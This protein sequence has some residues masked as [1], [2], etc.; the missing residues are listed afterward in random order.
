MRSL[1]TFLIFFCCYICLKAQAPA[2]VPGEILIQL[3]RRKEAS[4]WIQNHL[5]KRNSNYP[6]IR[7]LVPVA[8]LLHIWKIEFDTTCTSELQLLQQLRQDPAIAFAQFNHY[9][10]LRGIQPNDPL[11]PQQWQWYNRGQNGGDRGLD[12]GLYQAWD[13]TTGGL[14]ATGDSIVV[15]IIDSGLEAQH[16][17]LKPNTWFNRHEIPNNRKDDDGN[18]YIDDYRGWHTLQFNDNV[19]DNRLDGHGTG[20]AGLI[21]AKG[22]N[23][24]GMAGINW[25]IKLMPIVWGGENNGTEEVVIRGFTY[26]YTQRKLYNESK[27]KKGAYVV[28]VNA[29]WGISRLRSADFPI[30]CPLLDSLGQ[31]GV[32]TV[33]AAD[34]EMINTEELGDLPSDCPSNYL[35]V[36]TNI[37]NRGKL[38][39]AYGPHTVDL[40]APAQDILSTRLGE[41]YREFSGSSFAAPQV[42][43]AIALLYASPC[44][45]LANLAQNSPGEAALLA[46]RL[47]MDGVEPIADLQGKVVSGGYLRVDKSLR[48]LSAHCY[49]QTQAKPQ[50]LAN[51]NPFREQLLVPIRSAQAIERAN[52]E[53]F[54][55][56][57]QKMHSQMITVPAGFPGLVE[58]EASAWPAGMYIL[59]LR[60]GGKEMVVQK[61]IKL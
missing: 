29:S 43:G 4:F 13:T 36:V 53:V 14:S 50:L 32:L 57:G 12:I 41:G 22:N 1:F 20:V 9:V 2:H 42:A 54:N 44:I 3:E 47:I 21:G 17:D 19:N 51:P 38:L 26:V 15:A 46:R 25:D 6:C 8:E 34:R 28:A 60:W 33:N 16:V 39:Q 49:G 55:L 35:V 24:I 37:S 40:A 52:L 30:W 48:L 11:F 58:I 31:Q 23:G 56:Q 10:E 45:Q 7:A 59:R 18:G 61:V 5:E 27:G